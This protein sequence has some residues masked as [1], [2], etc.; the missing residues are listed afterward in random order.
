MIGHKIRITALVLLALASPVQ[1]EMQ[2]EIVGGDTLIIG[3]GP[4]AALAAAR[5]VVAAGGA[6][7]LGGT[8]GQDVHAMGFDVEIDATTTGDV[9]AMG[10]SVGLRGPVGGWCVWRTGG[11]E[12]DWRDLDL[13][14]AGK[15]RNPGWR[16]CGGTRHV[17]RA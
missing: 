13:F 6:V 4:N 2:T 10:F 9:T 17:L 1:A 16:H 11:T 7:T 5:D 12:P 14:D 3:S 8:V 15:G